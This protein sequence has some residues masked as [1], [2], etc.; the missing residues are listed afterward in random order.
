MMNLALI[1]A[2][3]LFFVSC[4][5]VTAPHNRPANGA[6]VKSSEDNLMSAKDG[7]HVTLK[8]VISFGEEQGRLSTSLFVLKTKHAVYELD[9]NTNNNEII[10]LRKWGYRLA[11]SNATIEAH[12]RLEQFGSDKVLVAFSII[13][14]SPN[15]PSKA[16]LQKVNK[17]KMQKYIDK[18][19]VNG[20]GE[21]IHDA[22][23]AVA[24][25]FKDDNQVKEFKRLRVR[26]HKSPYYEKVYSSA[27][28]MW[29]KV[30]F[31]YDVFG[32]FS[33]ANF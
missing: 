2:V 15:A 10:P 5:P 4:L 21:T 28:K 9:L 3:L 29:I 18:K 17:E 8:G 23:H 32:D 1:S 12:G 25:M 22:R 6:T 11:K 24:L 26:E 19:L 27:S 16:L 31:K 14:I 20:V 30:H 33:N 13:D 7:Q